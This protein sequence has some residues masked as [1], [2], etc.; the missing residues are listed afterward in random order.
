[1]K[2]KLICG[3]S[4]LSLMAGGAFAMRPVDMDQGD[5]Y[6][7][8]LDW[9]AAGGHFPPSDFVP[10][11]RDGGNTAADA[12][13]VTFVNRCYSD[14][15]TTV[16]KGD[17]IQGSVN[18]TQC[19][20]SSWYTGTSGYSADAWY[21]FSLSSSSQ[22][23]LSTINAYTAFDTAVMI[24]ASDGTTIIAGDDDAGG[25]PLWQ[26]AVTCLLSA[27]NYFAVIDG[28]GVGSEG[29][30]QMSLCYVP[31]CFVCPNNA[32]VHDEVG[33]GC[34]GYGN[35]MDCGQTWCGSIEAGDSDQY[36]VLGTTSY[37]PAHQTEVTLTLSGRG[38]G[39]DGTITVYAS[40]C[41]T[42]LASLTGNGDGVT[43]LVFCT[44]PTTEFVVD[45]TG[46][47]GSTGD[48][49]LALA[50]RCCPNANES[51]VNNPIYLTTASNFEGGATMLLDQCQTDK[52]RQFGRTAYEWISIYVPD[53]PCWDTIIR[54]CAPTHCY[55]NGQDSPVWYNY[56]AGGYYWCPS[57]T[58][59]C[60]GIG[61]VG[62]DAFYVDGWRTAS[63]PD[64]RLL[65]QVV[66]CPGSSISVEYVNLCVE[67]NEQPVA[68]DLQQN[69]PNPF[70]PTTSISYTLPEAGVASLKVFDTVG[71]EVATLADGMSER[72]EHTVVFDAGQFSTGVYFYTLQF[73]G[74]STT[75]KM[76]LVK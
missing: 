64:G 27:G 39:F 42:V 50:C 26:S 36:T 3:V 40:D 56:A 55:P 62:G 5:L 32:L 28:F 68:F 10:A 9:Y 46:A 14:Q 24:V 54:Y 49:S 35:I 25:S 59:W 7:Q 53:D 19:A 73:N 47:A 37:L 16:G 1:M 33:D 20:T 2:T 4:L 22:V 65:M 13:P 74:Q 61:A 15:G 57:C 12:T 69:V 31:G 60:S 11:D 48:Y 72:G 67:A 63:L 29:V 23:T 76:V 18:P 51:S 66:C 21:S 8:K 43:T 70:N 38:C 6:Q 30:Y 52:C 71:R 41:S 58:I 45:V 75:R 17:D 44:N 34:G